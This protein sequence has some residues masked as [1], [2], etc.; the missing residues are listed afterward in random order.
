MLFLL[1]ITVHAILRSAD[2]VKTPFTD[3]AACLGQYLSNSL[4]SPASNPGS[5]FVSYNWLKTSVNDRVPK[6]PAA[7]LL[8]PNI[9]FVSKAGI[10]YVVCMR[11]QF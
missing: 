11:S 6:N 7:V 1:L 9:S 8:L 5:G 3:L 4:Y 2:A 10:K